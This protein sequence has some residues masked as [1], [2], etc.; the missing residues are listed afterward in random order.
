MVCSN[1]GTENRSGREV[2][3]WMCV[4]PWRWCARHAARPTSRTQSSAASARRRSLAGPAPA[5]KPLVPARLPRPRRARRRASA[6]H[7]PLRR[8]R[9]VH[10]HSPRAATRRHAGA[11]LPLLRPRKRRDRP[12]RRDDR[13][14]HRRRGDGGLGRA[15]RPR[16]RRRARGPGGLELA[17]R[18]QALG[19]A[20]QARAG[21]LTGEA[22]VTLGRTE[23]GDGGR[24]PRQHGLPAAVGGPARERSSWGR[25]PSVPPPG[26]IV[27]EAAG[28]QLLKGKAAPVPAWRALRVVAERGG[29]NRAESLEA[30]FVGRDDELRLLKELF[31]ATGRERRARLVSVIG[32]AG[33]GKSRLAWEFLKYLDGLV[34]TVWWHD[35]R[36]PAYGEGISFW[37]LGEMVRGRCRPAR[38]RRRADNPGQDRRDARDPRARPGRAPLDRARPP[39]AARRRVAASAR[40]SCSGPGARSSSGWRRRRRSSWSSRTSTT[41]TPGCSTSSTTCSSGPGACPIYV[42]TLVPARA[43]GE[44]ADWGA[45][46]RNFTSVHL[47]PLPEPAMREL[48]AG[49]V[50]GLPES[51]VAGDRRPRRRGP[52]VCR[53]DGAHARRRRPARARRRRL[54]PDRRPRRLAVPET[55]TALIASRLDGL[56]P[57]GPGLVSDAAVLGQSFTLAGLAAVSGIARAR[58]RATACGP[59]CA[60]SCCPSRRT[61]AA[62]SGASTRSS[63]RSSG[64]SPTT[65]SR[66]PTASAAISPRPGSSRASRPTSWPAPWPATTSRPSRTRPRGRSRRPRRP[67][68]D[69][70]PGGRRPG[71]GPGVARA[72]RR[73]SAAGSDGHPRSRTRRQSCSNGPGE[74]A[75]AAAHHDEAEVT[76]AAGLELQRALGD[77]V[78]IARAI[79]A[80]GRALFGPT[81]PSR[82]SPSSSPQRRSSPT[83]ATDAAFIALARAARARV[84]AAHGH[85]RAI[86]VADRVLAVAERADPV[87]LVADTLVTKG[88][89]LGT[90]GRATRGW[91]SSRRACTSRSGTALRS[92]L[93][94]PA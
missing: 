37:A 76:A 15:D 79:T 28:E 57:R 7:G 22:A 65:R 87:A 46:K 1:C 44:A 51:A 43:P 25:P 40:N 86:E 23:P 4:A 52:A 33:I 54:P 59:W 84:H 27:F 69:R 19:P 30:P 36:S 71:R 10:R 61:R 56:A 11:P 80:L 12:L 92:R 24:R 74:C 39:R 66:G 26:A 42:V 49:L 5:A 16:G 85:R 20:S 77:R 2:L 81:G 55:L 89:A 94:V 32:P 3:H 88:T 73:L 18:R 78:A 9:R 64:R 63:R 67:G 29:R 72:G 91:A 53:R 70:P 50:P 14:V 83:S 47:E 62:R 75:S 38:G 35:G 58:P 41:P 60:A 93:V 68:A 82:P 31:H 45:G 8:S 34:E 17:R 90:L 48:L 21:V 6:R 13:E